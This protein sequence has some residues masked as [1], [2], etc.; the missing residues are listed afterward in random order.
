MKITINILTILWI[1]CASVFTAWSC[2]TYV[3]EYLKDHPE[4]SWVGD[5]PDAE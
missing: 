1:A 4:V 5:T 3:G 2:G